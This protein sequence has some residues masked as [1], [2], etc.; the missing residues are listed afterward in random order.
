MCD[1]RSN[2]IKS[3]RTTQFKIKI[4]K[5]VNIELS[6]NFLIICNSSNYA[7]RRENSDQHSTIQFL[8]N[9]E[10]TF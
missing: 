9:E 3:N 2:R 10:F 1:S 5:L 4:A 8:V 7:I 6:K